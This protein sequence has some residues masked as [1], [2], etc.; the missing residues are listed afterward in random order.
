MANLSFTKTFSDGSI[1]PASDLN[2]LQSDVST[3]INARNGGATAW[4]GL[5]STHSTN[6]PLT[7]NNSSG[8][9]DICRMQD[10]G[11]NVFQLTDGGYLTLGSQPAISVYRATS[12]Q[13]VAAASSDKV[14]FNTELFDV[15]NEYDSA[16]NFRY[17]ATKAGKY[18][19]SASLSCFFATHPTLGGYIA[20][21][22]RVN[23][24]NYMMSG[25]RIEE[26]TVTAYD[27]FPSIT[28]ILDLAASDYVEIYCSNQNGE[29]R[30]LTIRAGSAAV[31]WSY[32]N[33][34]KIA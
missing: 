27:Y 1:L 24:G 4:D 7:I 12:N 34:Y 9:Q 31:N 23:G 32:F 3:Y 18:L 33:V 25:Q 8:T 21:W 13:T 10:N 17:T 28:C 19:V 30:S 6:I 26:T 20:L 22:A 16:T 11:T 5:S 15:K 29:A 2:T 14:Q